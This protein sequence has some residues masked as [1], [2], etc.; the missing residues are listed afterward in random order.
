MKK[1]LTRKGSKKLVLK[2]KATVKC[3]PALKVIWLRKPTEHTVSWAQL[4]MEAK[5]Q[6]ISASRM[7]QG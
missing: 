1:Q 2:K 3:K 5:C 4:G 6:D 7:E